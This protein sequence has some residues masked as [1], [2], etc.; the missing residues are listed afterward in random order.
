MPDIE[1]VMLRN[2]LMEL[3]NKENALLRKVLE[4]A[5]PLLPVLQDHNLTNTARPL[6]EAVFEFDALQQEIHT[7]LEKNPHQSLLVMLE[8]ITSARDNR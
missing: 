8:L 5:R 1:T 6:S 2:Q 3:K 7:L 4:T